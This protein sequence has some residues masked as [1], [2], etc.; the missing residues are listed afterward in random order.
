[1]AIR[2]EYEQSWNPY[3]GVMP[4]GEAEIQPA[5]AD[6]LGCVMI[7]EGIS[8]T[9]EGVIS[10]TG[11]SGGGGSATKY[12]TNAT[13]KGFIDRHAAIEGD[14]LLLVPE[15]SLVLGTN[16]RIGGYDANRVANEN[17]KYSDIDGRCMVI[18]ECLAPLK[19]G[20]V[21]RGK[22][23]LLTYNIPY[24]SE[25][26]DGPIVKLKNCRIF[27]HI[28]SNGSAR[29][30]VEFEKLIVTNYKISAGMLS[31]LNNNA[32]AFVYKTYSD[33]DTYES[34]KN[35]NAFAGCP[36][37][38]ITEL[39][40]DVEPDTVQSLLGQIHKMLITRSADGETYLVNGVPI[41]ENSGPS[42][43][44]PMQKFER[45]PMWFQKNVCSAFSFIAVGY[46][47]ATGQTSGD[48]KSTEIMVTGSNFDGNTPDGIWRI[49][50]P[51]I[52][53]PV[54]DGAAVGE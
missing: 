12:Q 16:F 27:K 5:T 42:I 38:D 14:E 43:Y 47:G 28:G 3:W 11:G 15:I 24:D 19:S 9:E 17:Y 53:I 25:T 41:G 13:L 7:G 50:A 6:E 36:E 33:G 31:V 20:I 52:S 23:A 10:T 40:N 48:G 44:A 46:G 26:G 22:R 8:V 18:G 34:T 45:I 51:Y 49:T 39:Y 4:S 54:E 2:K 32:T 21:E 29:F 30:E 1:M 37:I 35:I